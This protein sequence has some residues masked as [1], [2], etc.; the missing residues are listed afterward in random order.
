MAKDAITRGGI[1]VLGSPVYD[2][3]LRYYFQPTQK[4]ENKEMHYGKT[5]I[6]LLINS[7]CRSGGGGADTI[8]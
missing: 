1:G 6:S 8:A 2:T 4:T 7:N 3:P 5:W